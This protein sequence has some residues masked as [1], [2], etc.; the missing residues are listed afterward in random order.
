LEGLSCVS[1]D[2]YFVGLY[3]A[4]FIV[5]TSSIFVL[6]KRCFDGV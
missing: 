5:A 1:L 6:L 3:E 4:S 2:T